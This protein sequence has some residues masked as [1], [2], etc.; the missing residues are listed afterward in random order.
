MKAE[1]D[2]EEFEEE[3]YRED[4]RPKAPRQ[5]ADDAVMGRVAN[6]ELPLVIEVHRP[7]ELRKLLA[8]TA[9]FDRLRLIIAGGSGSL[10]PL[11]WRRCCSA[12]P[13]GPP[14]RTPLAKFMC[15]SLT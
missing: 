8:D 9:R 10:A 6:G 14:P 13:P 11:R 3:R 15:P 5:N 7:M 2:G 4:R 12:R 1:E